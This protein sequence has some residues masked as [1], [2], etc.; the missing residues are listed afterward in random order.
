MWKSLKTYIAAFGKWGFI[1][2]AIL[3][4]DIL[5][6]IRSYYTGWLIPTWGWWLILVVILIVSPFIAFHKLRVQ[7]DKLKA[8]LQEDKNTPKLPSPP[9]LYLDYRSSEFGIEN[10]A[11][12]I[13][14]SAWYRATAGKMRISQVEL[15]LL[16]KVIPPL[17]WKIIEIGG[18]Y[19]LS[20]S[21][22]TKFELPKGISSGEHKAELFAIANDQSWGP[23]TF[24]VSV[25]EVNS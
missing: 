20:L 1:M 11:R 21:P 18:E 9:E 4:G 22:N 5:G 12:I 13:I 3:V 19:G 10:D 6:I 24:T 15:H 8:I 2:V 25:P 23:Y 7:R 17:N 14:I 16:D